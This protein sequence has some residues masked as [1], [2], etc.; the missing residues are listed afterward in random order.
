MASRLASLI[1]FFQLFLTPVSSAPFS[2]PN[3]RR[4]SGPSRA[5]LAVLRATQELEALSEE[6]EKP[7]KPPPCRPAATS[8]FRVTFVLPSS[9][10]STPRRELRPR[11]AH[12]NCALRRCPSRYRRRQGIYDLIQLD[13]RL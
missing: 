4:G 11:Q 5:P 9:T 8:S 7:P 2:P 10:P 13:L 6:V 1:N 12:C 3:S